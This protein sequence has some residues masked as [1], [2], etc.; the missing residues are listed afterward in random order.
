MFL[1]NA[2]GCKCTT[3]KDLDDLMASQAT[4]VITKSC[5]MLPRDGNKHPK[6]HDDGVHSINSNGLEN[7]G[8]RSYLE[9]YTERKDKLKEQ[10]K[11]FILSVAGRTITDNAQILR[12]AAKAGVERAELNLSC[13]NL[14]GCPV[15]LDIDLY[16]EWL[17]AILYGLP[18]SLQVGLKLPVYC[19]PKDIQA[20]AVL[21]Q[22]LPAVDSITCSNS[23]PLGLVYGEDGEPVLERV[24]GGCGG[25]D[26][27][28]AIVLGQIYQFN[29]ALGEDSGVDIVMCGGIRS[30]RDVQEGMKAGA[31]NFQVG[32]ALVVHGP[33]VF[34]EIWQHLECNRFS[35]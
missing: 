34:Q 12:E 31:T 29:R 16:R 24:L 26:T 33:P 15:S 23:L 28:K 20:V 27:M 6:Y 3:W 32:T 17:L 21:A 11:T 10:G 13:P 4:A 19:N 8:Y 5:T 30:G 35:P 2:A 22:E 7:L 18:D 25:G 14:D 9:W 1:S